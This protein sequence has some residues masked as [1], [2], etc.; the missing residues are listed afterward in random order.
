M[1]WYRWSYIIYT[2]YTHV[3]VYLYICIYVYMYEW[4][5]VNIHHIYKRCKIICIK[6]S[7]IIHTK[8]LTMMYISIL[9]LFLWCIFR[10]YIFCIYD[11]YLIYIIYTKDVRSK[12]LTWIMTFFE[13]WYD[14]PWIKIQMTW[15]WQHTLNTLNIFT[16]ITWITWIMTLKILTWIIRWISLFELWRSLLELWRWRSLLESYVEYPYLNYEYPYLNY[17]M[18]TCPYLN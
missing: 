1:S 6:T 2:K 14:L 7:Y 16:W 15:T 4:I 18:H 12:D 9:H 10:S 5:D 17:D 8:D 11:V 3:Y 13:L